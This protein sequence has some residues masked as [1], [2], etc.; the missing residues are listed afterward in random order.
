MHVTPR[1]TH[2]AHA[3]REDETMRVALLRQGTVASFVW[4]QR[5]EFDRSVGRIGIEGRKEGRKP[6]PAGGAYA[7]ARTSSAKDD[8]PRFV[9]YS[10]WSRLFG[11]AFRA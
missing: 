11:G 5:K 1:G 4:G 6:C 8:V 2:G 10:F 3:A 9:V 7:H